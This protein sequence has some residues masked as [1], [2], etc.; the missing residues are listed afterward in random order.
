MPNAKMI[1][2]NHEYMMLRA[3]GCPYDDFLD[4]GNA[5]GHWYRNGGDLT[6]KSLKRFSV[7]PPDRRFSIICTVCP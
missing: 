2:G 5:M 3:L 7:R 4:D 6:H 1:L